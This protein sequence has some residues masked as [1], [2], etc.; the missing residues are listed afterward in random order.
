MAELNL[1]AVGGARPDTVWLRYTSFRQWPTWSPYI[2]RVR[3]PAESLAEG[4]RGTVRSFLG[5]TASFL[6]ESVDEAE[7]SWTWR[8]R[9]GPLRMRLTHEVR[10]H[11]EGT[12]TRL[13]M[14]GPAPV[15][16]AYAPLARLALRRLVAP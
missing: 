10:P 11:G 2:V 9:F 13:R 5:I 12:E 3:V 6:V 8:V 4:V 7:R 16:A 14:R 1:R 15:L